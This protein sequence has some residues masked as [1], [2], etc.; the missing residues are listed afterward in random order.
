MGKRSSTETIV[1]IVMAFLGNRTWSQAALADRVGISTEAVR[2]TLQEM[3][4]SGLPLEREEEPPHVMW[5][6]PNGWFPGGVVLRAKDAEELLRQLARAPRTKRRDELMA[7]ILDASGSTTTASDARGIESPRATEAE[8]SF[9][10]VVEDAAMRRKALRMA[11]FAANRGAVE[12][13]HVSVHRVMAGA[14]VRF[15]ATC[16]RSGTLKWF[17]VNNVLAASLDDT[18]PYR[19]CDVS[20]VDR[21][22]RESVDGFHQGVEAQEERFVVRDPDARWVGRNLLDGMTS[23]P[24]AG[25]IRVTV[26]TSAPQRVARYVVGLGGAASAETEGLATLVRELARGALEAGGATGVQ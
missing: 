11:Y 9:L 7:R 15:V 8:E 13:R 2:R 24:V 21:L 4:A 6:V 14:A 23:E 18:E 19:A 12:R 10:P 16:H 20:E 3:S 25:G 5:S 22:V 1:E 26:K 17:R